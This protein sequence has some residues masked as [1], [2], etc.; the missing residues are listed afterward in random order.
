MR[1]WLPAI[2]C[3]AAALGALYVHPGL[4]AIFAIV[5]AAFIYAYTK[6]WRAH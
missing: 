4:W 2:I 1:L 5:L 6:S 3:W